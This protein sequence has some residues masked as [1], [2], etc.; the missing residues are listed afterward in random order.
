MGTVRRSPC[1][2][3]PTH[4]LHFPSCMDN[5]CVELRVW[6]AKE[7]FIGLGHLDQKS[8]ESLVYA[9]KPMNMKMKTFMVLVNAR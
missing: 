6:Q 7:K 2:G 8:K 9:T 1:L 4:P 3:C 5:G